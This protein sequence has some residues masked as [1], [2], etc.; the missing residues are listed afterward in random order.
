VYTK[1]C[2]NT[3][4]RLSGTGPCLT[5]SKSLSSPIISEI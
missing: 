3:R 4:I 5:F 2:E 1:Q